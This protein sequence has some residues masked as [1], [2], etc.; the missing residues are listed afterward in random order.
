[1]IVEILAIYVLIQCITL[2]AR[3]VERRRDVFYYVSGSSRAK[4]GRG[5]NDA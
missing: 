4:P 5:L 1:M 2:F 3:L